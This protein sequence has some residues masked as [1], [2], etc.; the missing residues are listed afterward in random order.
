[1]KNDLN[2][3]KT[4]GTRLVYQ[5][6]W[7]SVREDSV[8]RPDGSPGIYGVVDTRI[9]TGVIA[10]TTKQEVYLIG[11]WR[12]P[13]ERYSWEIVEGGTDEGELPLDAIKRELKE[14]AGLVA[15]EWQ[16]LG[17]EVHLSNCFSSER[18]LLYVASDLQ[19][20][21]SEPDATEVLQVKK[22]PLSE[23]LAMIDSGEITDAM[24]VIG[25]LRLQQCMGKIPVE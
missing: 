12:Y 21:P 7:I 4:V 6:E 19:K 24:S 20:V 11:Q 8:L 5:N 1:M 14:E 22:V 10:L 23:C 16:Q 18:A 13:L 9:A 15:K 17:G 2:P 25:L 3:W